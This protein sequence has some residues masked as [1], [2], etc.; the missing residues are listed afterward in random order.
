MFAYTMKEAHP[1]LFVDM[2]L[3]KCIVVIRRCKLYKPRNP[4]RGLRILVVAPS[5]A[6]GSWEEHWT[7]EGETFTVLG[8]TKAERKAK[9]EADA[10]RWFL[11]NKEGWQYL[12]QIAQV[13]WD[14]VVL[15]ESHF[16]K[17]PNSKVTKFFLRNFRKV[18]HRWL[19]TG[20]PNEEDDSEYVC[21][22][23]FLDGHF[24]GVR[25]FWAYRTRYLRPDYNGH[26]WIPRPGTTK[27]LR[28]KIGK[29]A[30]ILRKKDEGLEPNT[31]II[32]W[33]LEFP[34]PI[35]KLY[36]KAES[37]FEI[38]D[39][40]TIWSMVR[41]SWLQSLCGG[42]VGEEC[43]WEGKYEQLL[44]ILQTQLK[45]RPVVVLFHHNAEIQQAHDYL[46]SNG[47]LAYYIWGK[48]PRPTREYYR[49]DFQRGG[50][51]V[52]LVQ[53]AVAT[54]GMDLSRA[55]TIIFFSQNPS[56]RVH[57]Q[58]TERI[59]NFNKLDKTLLYIYLQVKDSVDSD[60]YN[61]IRNKHFGSDL[62]LSQ[63]LAASIKERQRARKPEKHR[64]P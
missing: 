16:I 28:E 33:E 57:A 46:N 6:M 24:L 51:N 17:S 25:N 40:T 63:S 37:D 13:E 21:Q 61:A 52:F 1:A 59:F 58:I 29:R 3:G 20:T 62:S 8:G 49:Q 10:T 43:V 14:A 18:P 26:G 12:P 23:L 9:L 47:M 60:K 50:F 15:D 7:D 35:R 30:F 44:Y 2:R 42:F 39:Q 55:D 48:Q 34:E 22:M 56:G 53:Q 5:S 19:L 45:N 32:K 4:K 31:E 38:D 36:D 54:E 64:H 27:L 41:Y 11:I